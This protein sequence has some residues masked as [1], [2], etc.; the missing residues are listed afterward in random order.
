[1]LVDQ[2]GLLETQDSGKEC[3]LMLCGSG[4][5]KTF[6]FLAP[7]SAEFA[8]HHALQ[9]PKEFAEERSMTQ[10]RFGTAEG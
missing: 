5:S 6:L 9:K 4:W 7:Y 1:M 3:R 10:R 8:T 2:Q